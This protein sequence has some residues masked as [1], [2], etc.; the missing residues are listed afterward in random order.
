M[1]E[2]RPACRICLAQRDSKSN[3]LLSPCDCRGSVRY[4]HLHCLNHWRYIDMGKNGE[5]CELCNAEYTIREIPI[6]EVIPRKD[7]PTAYILRYPIVLSVGIHYGVIF[8]MT[9]RYPPSHVWMPNCDY[10][11]W[12]DAFMFSYLCLLSTQFKVR[13][14]GL[15]RRIADKQKAFALFSLHILCMWLLHEE[16]LVFGP[17]ANALLGFYWKLHMDTLQDMNAHRAIY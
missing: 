2:E 7:T 12:Q 4:I 1:G 5:R 8:I 15:Y 13:Q 11:I 6:Q 9:F 3:P 16:Y 17:V 10:I 14:P